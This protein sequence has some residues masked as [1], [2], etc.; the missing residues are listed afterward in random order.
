MR[1]LIPASSVGN[2]FDAIRLA[3]ALLVVWSHSFI[4]HTGTEDREWVNVLLNETYTAGTIA[5]M[6]FFIIS[7]FLIAKSWERS[8]SL[9]S[10][11]TKRVR[12]IYPGYM[13]ATAI[14]AFIVVPLFATSITPMSPFRI[15]AHNLLLQNVFPKSDAFAANPYS[16]AINGSLWSI[17]FEFKC[18]LMVA[19]LGLAGLATRGRLLIA[20]TGALMFLRFALDRARV[21]PHVGFAGDLLLWAQILPSFLLGMVFY[22]YRDFLPRSR[23]SL[24]VVSLTAVGSCWIGLG[25]VMV[26]PA[27]AYGVFYIAYSDRIRLRGA[28]Q[29]G[30]FSYGTYLYAFVIQQMLEAT[31]RL[32]LPEFIALSTALSL[33]AGA[34]SWHLVEKHFK[35]HKADPPK[36]TARVSVDESYTPIS[37]ES[38]AALSTDS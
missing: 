20:V 1:Q 6:A 36:A 33:L 28:A 5:V 8:N 9:G 17:P 23:T 15:I 24:A 10:F 27:L 32:T 19:A 22:S 7:G 37:V 16:N 29:F 25:Y 12:R 34:L 13:V 21:V 14:C 35:D 2:N 31:V 26:A 4:L 18:Y 38:A 3:M 30:D 11:L